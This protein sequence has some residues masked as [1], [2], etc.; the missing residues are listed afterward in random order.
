MAN[1]MS[2]VKNILKFLQKEGIKKTGVG[3]APIF[4]ISSK[5]LRITC[6]TRESKAGNMVL[7]FE[8]YYVAASR[9]TYGTIQTYNAGE[10]IEVI[11][12]I[13]T[14]RDLS[15][16]EQEQLKSW[17]SS[18]YDAWRTASKTLVVVELM[19]E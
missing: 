6:T 3:M 1:V 12:S 7:D 2:D 18:I 16:E 15:E 17:N 19:E 11:A 9:A 10:E 4:E 13:R 5:R 14:P 8:G